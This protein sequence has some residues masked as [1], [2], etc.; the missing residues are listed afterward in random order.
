[1]KLVILA[2][3]T[4]QDAKALVNLENQ[5]VLLSGDEYHDKI[6]AKIEGFI[7]G[8]NVAGAKHEVVEEGVLIDEENEEFYNGVLYIQP[9]HPWFTLVGFFEED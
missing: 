2:N 5:E 7:E 4:M 1:M 9:G 8:L 3:E 6:S